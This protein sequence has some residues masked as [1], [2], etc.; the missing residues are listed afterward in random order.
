M[1]FNEI[2]EFMNNVM[3]I[4]MA[5]TKNGAKTFSFKNGLPHLAI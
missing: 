5:R 4:R 1:G 3:G 2:A